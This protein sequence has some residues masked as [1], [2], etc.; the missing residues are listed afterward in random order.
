MINTAEPSKMGPWRRDLTA[1]VRRVKW[2]LNR[3]RKELNVS[4]VLRP[5]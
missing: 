5:S 3:E 1:G 2:R 4:R